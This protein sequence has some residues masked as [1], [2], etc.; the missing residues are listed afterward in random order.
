MILAPTAEQGSIPR[1]QE[2]QPR[3]RAS[4]AEEASILRSWVP[5]VRQPVFCVPRESFRQ[6]RSRHAWSAGQANF[7]QHKATMLRQT[8]SHVLRANILHTLEQLQIALAFFA[9]LG[10]TQLQSAQQERASVKCVHHITIL[11][12]GVLLTQPAN[13]WTVGHLCSCVCR[14]TMELLEIALSWSVLIHAVLPVN[15]DWSWMGTFQILTA[16]KH[17]RDSSRHP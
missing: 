2:R 10:N 9:L 17:L 6:R 3:A 12:L 14:D 11:L 8:A 16:P 4:V 1:P 7:W 13:H 5:Q 15:C